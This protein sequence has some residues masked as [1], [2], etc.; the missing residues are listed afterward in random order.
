[1][2]IAPV[3]FEAGNSRFKSSVV[4]ESEKSPLDVLRR[5]IAAGSVA[6]CCSGG[7]V[8]RKGLRMV[9]GMVVTEGREVFF[10]FFF[11]AT[12]SW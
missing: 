2:E 1:M 12:G 11:L 5:L 8:L 7:A 6:W 9:T 10:F 4:A 3:D